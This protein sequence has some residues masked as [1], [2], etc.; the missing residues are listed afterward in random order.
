MAGGAVEQGS[1][2]RAAA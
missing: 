2:R 1:G